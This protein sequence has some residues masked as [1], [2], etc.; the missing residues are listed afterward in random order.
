MANV[1]IGMMAA[2]LALESMAAEVSKVTV[3][4]RWPW[5]RL[6]DID[7]VLSC[8]PSEK[9]DVAVSLFNGTDPTALTI[10]ATSLSGDLNGISYG[11]HRIVWDPMATSYTNS[12]TQLTE[13]RAS[14]VPTNSP[15][16][17]I[18]DLTNAPGTLAHVEYIYPGDSRLVTEGRYTNVWFDVTNHS[19]YATDKLVLRRVH[20]GTF[21]MGT[22]VPPTLPVTLT[23]D[24]YVG[25]FELTQAQWKNVTTVYPGSLFTLE[26]DTRPAEQVTYIDIRGSTS[27]TPAVNWP[28][29]GYLVATNS[30]I[31]KLRAKTGITTFDLPTEAQWSCA[32]RAGTTTVFNDG[33]PNAQINITGTLVPNNNGYTNGALTALGRYSWNGGKYWDGDS[34]EN[35]LSSSFGPA[36]G[37]AKVGSYLPNNWGLYD[38]LGNVWDFCLDWY[39]D[40]L[41]GG[42]DPAGSTNGTQRVGGGGRF[43]GNAFECT[44]ATRSGIADGFPH[45]VIG[46]RVVKTLP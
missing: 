46:F 7:Y 39:A 12:G 17:M 9:M 27:G 13:L 4:Q 41:Q 34:W 5:S 19:E 22:A 2:C 24:F 44:S 3:R 16:Y 37:T 42:T 6:V 36:N 8:A 45:A 23:K 32:C 43:I 29:T 35:A 11:A 28:L 38:T 21:K 40:T 30:F 10:P 33:D 18:V 15:I 1:F 20:A 25:V 26:R 31:G 14:L